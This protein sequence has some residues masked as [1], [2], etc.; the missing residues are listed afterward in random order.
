MLFRHRRVV[1]YLSRMIQVTYLMS[2]R[3]RRSLPYMLDSFIGDVTAYLATARRRV[4]GS[5]VH[6][7][8]EQLV[9]LASE[10]DMG[11]DQGIDAR[12]SAVDE[13]SL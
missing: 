8:R 9:P 6:P 2:Q 4:A 7:R 3:Q 10:G 1:P 5:R 13:K 11:G 12:S